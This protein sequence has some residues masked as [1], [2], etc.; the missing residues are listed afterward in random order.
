MDP[1]LARRKTILAVVAGFGGIAGAPSR[2]QQL[3]F[4][5]VGGTNLT[6]DL[7]TNDDTYTIDEEGQAPYQL[8]VLF[9]SHSHSFI[10]DPM[11]EVSLPRSFSV[12]VNALHRDLQS[13]Q[14]VTSLF[15]GGPPRPGAR[16]GS[17]FRPFVKPGPPFRTWQEPLAVEP[18]H[19]GVSAGL[20]VAMN[21]GKLAV[22]AGSAVHP[23]GV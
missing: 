19:Y 1:M 21:W 10:L 23:V 12:E 20:S 5:L 14:V 22:R 11:M 6:H 16:G 4:G 2:A 9:Y 15:A 13:T 7:R 3:R 18:S 17:R 8:N